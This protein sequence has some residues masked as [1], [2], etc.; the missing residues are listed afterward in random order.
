MSACARSALVFAAIGLLLGLTPAAGLAQPAGTQMIGTIDTFIDNTI[1]LTDGTS[2]PVTEPVRVTQLRRVTPAG[3]V[4][5]QYVAISAARDPDGVLNASFVNAFPEAARGTGEG[6]REMTE[7]GFCAPLCR[8]GDLMTN[9][10]ID[11]AQLDAVQGGELMI[12]FLGESS[13]ARV[14]PDTRIA[15]QSP[16]SSADIAPGA[17]VI[18]F[19]N[20]Q[21]VAG[22]VWVYVS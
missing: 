15:I 14:N 19:V 1:T 17:D 4:P 9:A 2:F 12:T 16:G 22:G 7:V 6:Q 8:P 3:L 18:G 21:G 13:R 20:A 10:T 11:D 5:G